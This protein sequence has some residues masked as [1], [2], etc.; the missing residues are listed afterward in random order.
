MIVTGRDAVHKAVERFM[1]KR[2]QII[3]Q[4]MSAAA[5]LGGPPPDR[6]PR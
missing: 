3:K 5:P 1:G 2:Q 4:D 6:A